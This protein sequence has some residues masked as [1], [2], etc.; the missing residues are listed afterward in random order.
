[1]KNI[2]KEINKLPIIRR[3]LAY[4]LLYFVALMI[5]GFTFGFIKGILFYM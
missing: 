1:M 5:I 4:I 2:F 3:I